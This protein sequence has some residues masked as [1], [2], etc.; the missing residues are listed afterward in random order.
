MSDKNKQ[1]DPGKLELIATKSFAPYGDMYRV[2][3]FLNK[4]LKEKKV[5]FG[6]TKSREKEMMTISIYEVE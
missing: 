5:M 2:V 4:S 3:D 1:R 6:L